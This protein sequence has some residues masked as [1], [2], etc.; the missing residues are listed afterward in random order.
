VPSQLDQ[1]VAKCETILAQCLIAANQAAAA[2]SEISDEGL[3]PL[4]SPHFSGVP[5]TP[6]PPFFDTSDQIINSAWIA[7]KLGQQNG[8]ATLDPGGLIP[9]NQLPFASL[10]FDGVWDANTNTPHLTSSSGTAGHFFVVQVSGST[11]LNGVSTWNVGD[12]ALFNGTIWQR[13][14]FQQPPITQLPLSALQT[15]PT[16]TVVGNISGG[17]TTPSA[18]TISQITSFLSV[19]LPDTGSGGSAGLVP[20][21]PPG[22]AGSGSF[23]R[24]DGVWG[25]VGAPNLSAYALLN[26]PAFAG[27]ATVATQARGNFGSAIASTAFV[28]NQQAQAS[29]VA[30]LRVNGTASAG[31]ST[32][33]AKI[34]H[35]HGTDTSR[36]PTSG[37]VATNLTINGSGPINITSAIVANTLTVANGLGVSAGGATIAGGI[38]L[39]GDITIQRAGIAANT[40]AAFFGNTGTHYIFWDG[41]TFQF[42]GPGNFVGAL[43]A[44]GQVTGANLPAMNGNAGTFL[45]G[46]GTFSIPTGSGFTSA[47]FGL[48]N[49]GGG[50]VGMDTNNAQGIGSYMQLRNIGVN[51]PGG[52][53]TAS[54][55]LQTGI[56]GVDGVWSTA[57]GAPGSVWRAIASINND[58]VGLFIRV[59]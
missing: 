48:A 50:Q 13:I 59:S 49:Y 23:L 25:S 55:N 14:P 30:L 58:Q 12:Q 36:L 2:V 43:A 41:A 46:A 8:I 1:T 52:S 31:T 24:A 18:I 20:A 9:I 15:I 22:S 19:M 32:Y 4:A 10:T 11:S 38:G 53:T 3:A 6:T 47:I 56:Q 37:G 28:I 16:A 34:D 7:E 35:I 54:S 39:T 40:G 51:V 29:E 44:S 33:S 42:N 26:S 17:S 45:N 5:T 27:T 21:P 57:G